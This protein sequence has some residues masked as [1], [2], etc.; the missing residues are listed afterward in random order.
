MEEKIEN[1]IELLNGIKEVLEKKYNPLFFTSNITDDVR[2]GRYLVE[3]NRIDSISV[4][5]EPELWEFVANANR[6]G[7][8]IRNFIVPKLHSKQQHPMFSTINF[9]AKNYGKMVNVLRKV[10]SS[11]NKHNGGTIEID[12][13]DISE[14]DEI[15]LFLKLL[16]QIKNRILKDYIWDEE[17]KILKL[18]KVFDLNFFTG[19]WFELYTQLNLI[20][21][22][23]EINPANKYIFLS[24]IKYENR[25]GMSGEIDAIILYDNNL[26]VFELKTSLENGVLPAYEKKVKFLKASLGKD[27]NIRFYLTI[28]NNHHTNT[29]N[30]QINN[31][32]EN[33]KELEESP[34]LPKENYSF[35]ICSL[36]ELEKFL[37][38]NL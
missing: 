12:L 8:F 16:F 32:T 28:P 14:E 19:N 20:N 11:L 29:Q 2:N 7:V 4:I 6:N 17:N 1:I 33:L 23:I 26:Y 37:A 5:N 31:D 18:I 27:Y 38:E 36:N 10:K 35:V 9:L 34:E 30:T 24:N 21:T 15:K 13:S 3:I 25:Y 22:F